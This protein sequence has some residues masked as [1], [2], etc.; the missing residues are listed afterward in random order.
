MASSRRFRTI[1]V[2]RKGL[3]PGHPEP[4]LSWHSGFWGGAHARPKTTPVH[5]ATRWCGGHVAAG[6]SRAVHQPLD[7][8][9]GE[10]APHDCQ[11]YDVW[12]ALLGSVFHRDKPRRGVTKLYV[13]LAETPHGEFADLAVR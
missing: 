2:Y 4:A 6:G 10:V 1:Q 3:L 7:L 8:A 5:H 13:F 9:L 11:V 12:S